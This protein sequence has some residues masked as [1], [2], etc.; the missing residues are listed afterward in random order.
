MEPQIIKLP[1]APTCLGTALNA[2]QRNS[3]C[4]F[5]DSNKTH[6][7]CTVQAKWSAPVIQQA[8]RTVHIV[9]TAVRR[10]QDNGKLFRAP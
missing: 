2:A 3:R 8:V 1:E 6:V 5:G 7:K 4:L 10:V 9:T